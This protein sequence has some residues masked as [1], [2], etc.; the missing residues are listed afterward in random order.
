MLSIGLVGT[1]PHC[2]LVLLAASLMCVLWF[3]ARQV[4]DGQLTPGQLSAFVVYSVYVS[5]NVGSLAGVFSN[6]MQVRQMRSVVLVYDAHLLNDSH[7]H[8]V[9]GISCV[10]AVN[11]SCGW[12]AWG[13]S[14][15]VSR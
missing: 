2:C 7:Q 15:W 8:L 10:H 3:G 1:W 9:A 13:W 14:H 4:I 12:C 5:G 11:T 6:L